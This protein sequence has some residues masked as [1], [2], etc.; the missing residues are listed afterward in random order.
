MSSEA[1]LQSVPMNVNAGPGTL[2]LIGRSP[3][4]QR[5]PGNSQVFGLR[6][7]SDHRIVLAP[8]LTKGSYAGIDG[9]SLRLP[10]IHP[11]NRA[12]KP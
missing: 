6:R 12:G 2:L 5:L 11:I 10:D 8:R 1:V 3:V 7:R 4:C 9:V